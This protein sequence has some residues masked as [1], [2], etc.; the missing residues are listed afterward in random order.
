MYYFMSD[1]HGAKEAYEKMKEKIG[2]KNN[3]ELYI[4]GDIF[5]GN[6][7]NPSACLE[8][9]NDIMEH[10][11]IHLILGDHEYAHI[12]Y[13]LCS[14]DDDLQSYWLNYLLSN[15]AKPLLE[16]LC[17]KMS[18]KERAL[19]LKFLLTCPIT[20]M[21]EIGAIP[22][23]LVHGSPVS[24]G[25]NNMDWQEF[26]TKKAIKLDYNYKFSIRSD[27]N[28]YDYKKK[29][30]QLDEDKIKIICGHIETKEIFANN[31]ELYQQFYQDA[32]EKYQK[33]LLYK[34]KVLLNCGCTANTIGQKTN[35][36]NPDLSCLGADAAGF[37]CIHLMD[38]S[39]SYKRYNPQRS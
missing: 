20:D 3:D 13:Q 38:G 37:F 34:D 16:Y 32:E 33:V 9:L 19:Y 2:F 22:L 31:H 18:D 36:W 11:N 4:L 10:D 28:F 21:L 35:G 12:M 27:P 24:C 39:S 25:D 6:D 8:I 30:K 14:G 23:Y 5:D 29:I 17:N 1:I 7:E 15:T 26:V